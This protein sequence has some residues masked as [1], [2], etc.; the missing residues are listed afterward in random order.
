M[1][2]ATLLGTHFHYFIFSFFERKL[3]VQFPLLNDEFVRL[4]SRSDVDQLGVVVGGD[5]HR[6]DAAPHRGDPAL[7]Q[8][9]GRAQGFDLTDV[10]H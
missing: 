2:L 3:H 9:D 5:G 8:D 4:S 10:L 6:A 1:F 7:E